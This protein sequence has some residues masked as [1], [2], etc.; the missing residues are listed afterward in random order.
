M[1]NFFS[2]TNPIDPNDPVGI[3]NFVDHAVIADANPPIILA[4][5]E[6]PAPKRP[7]VL[8]KRTDHAN[9]SV[10]NRVG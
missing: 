3:G 8:G 2:V 1:V 7:W 5:G 9:D 4:S 6:L 10:V